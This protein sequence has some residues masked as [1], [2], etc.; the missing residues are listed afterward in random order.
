MHDETE[1]N[2]Q[3]YADEC[4]NKEKNESTRIINDSINEWFYLLL[5]AYM[6]Q[7]FDEDIHD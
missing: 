5:N 1:G 2:D 3:G 4:M 6:I 7:G